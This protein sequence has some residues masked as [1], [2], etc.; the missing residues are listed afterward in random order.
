[1]FKLSHKVTLTEGDKVKVSAGPYFPSKLGTKIRMGYK[2][3]GTFVSAS[4]DGM[5]LRIKL[6]STIENVYIGPEYVSESTRNIMRPHK[7]TKLRKK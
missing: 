7:I 5:F 4:E 1:M 2:G 6:G 3:E